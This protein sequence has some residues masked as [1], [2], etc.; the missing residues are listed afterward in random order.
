MLQQTWFL[1]AG[2][3]NTY[4]PPPGFPKAGVGSF[5]VPIGSYRGLRLRSTDILAKILS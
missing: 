4:G 2:G 1:P 3:N 5:L